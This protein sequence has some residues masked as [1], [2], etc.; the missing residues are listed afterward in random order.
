[1]RRFKT[2]IEAFEES[3]SGYHWD[4]NEQTLKDKLIGGVFNDKEWEM[5]GRTGF[6]TNCHHLTK[7]EDIR[8]EN[9]K[10]PDPT[11]LKGTIGR[12]SDDGSWMNISDADEEELPF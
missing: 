9:F 1:M 5:N 11:Y 3:N 10:I 2:V 8:K 4:W 12:K 6:F 7:V